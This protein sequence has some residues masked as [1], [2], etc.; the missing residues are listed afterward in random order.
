MADWESALISSVA[1]LAGAV[2]GVWGTWFREERRRKVDA[3]ERGA[4]LAIM[5]GNALSVFGHECARVA[6]D[7]GRVEPSNGIDYYYTTVTEPTFDPAVYN[8]DWQAIP[9]KL[10]DQ[11][12]LLPSLIRAVRDRLDGSH[13]SG[14]PDDSFFFF[15]DQQYMY[16]ELGIHAFDAASALRAHAGL[17]SRTTLTEALEVR[18]KEIENARQRRMEKFRASISLR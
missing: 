12:L 5:V 4:Y 8:V 1:G 11:I 2:L 6:E 7:T 17:P 3:G 15:E 16:A 18:R 9:A 13:D 14:D 10:A